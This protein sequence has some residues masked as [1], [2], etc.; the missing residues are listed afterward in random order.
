MPTSP[1]SLA[2]ASLRGGAGFAFTLAG[3]FF[4]M[5]G[6]A[7]PTLFYPVLQQQIGFSPATI[8]A[9]FAIYAAALLAALLTV[10]SVS[11]H[12]GRRPALSLG[13]AG[14]ALGVLLFWQADS[15]GGL[16]TARA[17]QGAATGLLMPALTAFAVELEPRDR[18][19]TAAIWTAVL[20]LCGLAAGAMLSGLAMKYARHPGADVFGG[21]AL[22]YLLG[23]LL[24]WLLPETSPRL[25]GLRRAL[26]PRVG[27][28]APARATFWRSAPAVFAGWAIGGLY[29][30]L[31]TGIVSQV[32]GI[33]D[34]V[35]EAG[36]VLL[37]AGTG[38]LSTFLSRRV[39]QRQVML[40][41]TATLSIG[42]LVSLL[43][44]QAGAVLP[45]L[46]GLGLS[47]VGFG[48]CFYGTIRSLAPLASAETRGELFA[49]LYTLSYLAF[50]LPTI[51][52]GL[53]APQA[54]LLATATGY[55]LIVAL[56]AAVAWGWRR[57]ATRD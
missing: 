44:M 36:V 51:L 5:A 46:L 24:C 4:M 49:A 45:Y 8:S 57:F 19:G 22:L 20:P 54:G 2:A 27:V 25:E 53:I 28:P 6:A 32:F 9:I 48:T 17:V 29:L 35:S 34:P 10:G 56:A 18:P 13:F 7:A 47:G 50:G 16:L 38:A 39:H 3:A 43:G 1:A 23:A 31:G 33:R 14:L 40:T 11:D 26:R 21:L 42:T 52:A 15:V 41:G 37:L 30:S 55:G 12:I